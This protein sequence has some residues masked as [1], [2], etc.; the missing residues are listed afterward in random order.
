MTET[1]AAY[2]GQRV[3]VYDQKRHR[4]TEWQRENAIVRQ[5]CSTVPTG[6]R[7]LDIPCGTGRLFPFFFAR[8]LRVVGADLSEEMMAMIPDALRTSPLLEGLERCDAADLPYP[9]GHFDYVVCLR[10]FHLGGLPKEVQDRILVELMRVAAKGMVLHVC[11]EG[12]LVSRAMDWTWRVW[13]E[14]PAAALRVAAK[15]LRRRA[16]AGRASRLDVP[17]AAGA[18]RRPTSVVW[19]REELGRAFAAGGFQVVQEYGAISPF[20]S[21]KILVTTRTSGL[22]SAAAA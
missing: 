16:L 1:N 14:G 10:L 21:K 6:S 18:K 17:P 4:Q 13:R 2:I 5:W 7:V 9:D 15:K 8:G 3:A 11:L 12:S 22:P 20:S 19:N